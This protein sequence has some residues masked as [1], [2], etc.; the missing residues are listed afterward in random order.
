MTITQN[1]YPHEQNTI[2]LSTRSAVYPLVRD[3]QAEIKSSI[4]LVR[5]ALDQLEKCAYTVS[6]IIPPK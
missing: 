6:R 3:V 4:S 1:I 2:K 5:I